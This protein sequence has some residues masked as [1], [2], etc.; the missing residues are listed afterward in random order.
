MRKFID[1]REVPSDMNC[2]IAISADSEE[3]LIE[4]AAQHAVAVHGH[5]DSPELRDMLRSGLHEGAVPAAVAGHSM[6]G[7][8][9]L[10]NAVGWRGP[11]GRELDEAAMLGAC[12]VADSREAVLRES[13][14]VLL[15]G[16]VRVN[17]EPEERR[18][19][20]LHRGDVVSIE[21]G[22]EVRVG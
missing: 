9:V 1:C 18:G 15:S 2:S 6:G 13:G 10:D 5:Q 22:E 12:V 21:G 17:G 4:A 3:E 20:Q 8:V 16:A 11:T 14:D 7:R 19:R